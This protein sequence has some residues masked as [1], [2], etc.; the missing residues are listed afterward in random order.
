MATWKVTWIDEHVETIKAKRYDFFD[1][2]ATFIFHDGDVREPV[3]SIPNAGIR[4]I[5]R[6]D[7]KAI[8]ASEAEHAARFT[9]GGRG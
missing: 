3:A 6:T 7:K 5:R 2:D 1:G 9:I 4:V 8:L